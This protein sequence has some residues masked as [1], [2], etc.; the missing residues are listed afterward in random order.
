MYTLSVDNYM[1]PQLTR[2]R[3]KPERMM[4]EI[5]YS[6]ELPA[7]VLYDSIIL[8][9]MA[10]PLEIEDEATLMAIQAAKP[11][12]TV[13]LLFAQDQD[14]D[15]RPSVDGY[16]PVG[17]QARIQS[18]TRLGDSAVILHGIVRAEVGD[19]VQERP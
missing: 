11:S 13:L 15:D 10:G 18:D 19:C 4:A 16:H 17:V 12:E 8:P 14:D 7:V 9:H 1:P 2:A 6:T 3:G 5:A